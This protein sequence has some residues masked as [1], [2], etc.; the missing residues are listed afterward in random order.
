MNKISNQQIN[1]NVQLNEQS[2]SDDLLGAIFSV[3]ILVDEKNIQEVTIKSNYGSISENLN[4][5]SERLSFDKNNLD[6]LSSHFQLT[7]NVKNKSIDNLNNKAINILRLEIKINENLKNNI[8]NKDKGI[9]K[10]N[11]KKNSTAKIN[12]EDFQKKQI[13]S[14]LINNKN[15]ASKINNKRNENL[16]DA[17]NINPQASLKHI[18]DKIEQF[19]D[20]K[21]SE[22]FNDKLLP[23]KNEIIYNKLKLNSE[24]SIN[25]NNQI[26]KIEVT[27]TSSNNSNN[28]NNLGNEKSINFVLDKLIDELDMTQSGWTEKLV[29]KFNKAFKDGK[30]E[31]ELFLKPKELGTLKV[32][33]KMNDKN[34]RI[35]LKAENNASI[36]A[37]QA[38]EAILTK[39][40]SDSGLILEKL[41][42]ESF[43]M[44][45]QQNNSKSS[46]Q[47]KKNLI[48]ETNN[49]EIIK[50]NEI[51]DDNSNYIININA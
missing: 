43:Q 23:T 24:N 39:S 19:K 14:H 36:L 17:K 7:N 8:S 22:N 45:S 32:S 12:F 6:K 15:E 16:N 42:F 48:D 20:E 33:L 28:Q 34:A 1:L 4:G 10:I 44:G 37:L 13:Y 27:S 30:E 46:K 49:T 51:E 40:L 35:I 9:L 47:D 41:S 18:F 50:D 25:L 31:I 2:K 21:L 5:K 3:P 29:M 38:N 11:K 26:N